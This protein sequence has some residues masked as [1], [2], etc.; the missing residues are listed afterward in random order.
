MLSESDLVVKK[1]K[2]NDGVHF[3]VLKWTLF[4]T[5]SQKI[6]TFFGIDIQN[7]VETKTSHKN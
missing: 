1:I 2:T 6:L 7:S 5:H 3:S 4:L